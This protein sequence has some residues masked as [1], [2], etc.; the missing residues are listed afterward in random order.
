MKILVSVDIEGV[1]GVVG[2]EETRAGSPEHDRA[3][4]LMTAEASAAVA[5]ALAGGATEV[6]VAD[7]HGDF[8]NLL[9]DALHPAARAV[10]GKPRALGM[11]A[12]IDTGCA[13][14]FLV[15]YHAKARTRGNLA[16]TINSFAF[17]RV[18][19]NGDE[20]GEAALYGGLAGECGVPVALVT[21]DDVFVA[22]T[23]AWLPDAAVVVV[24]DALG[25]R[26]AASLAPS[27]ACEAIAAGAREAMRRIPAL[28]PLRFPAPL[29]VGVDATGPAL[30]DLFALLPLVRR[31]DA[32]AVEFDAGSMTD[33]VRVLNALSAM[34]AALR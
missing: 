7:A 22:E 30:A 15:G 4:R 23:R 9:P 26:S 31:V 29:T 13:A 33:A 20:I 6:L 14:A 16:H 18:L 32:T 12:G 10:R 19:V 5:G 28:A 2:P 27:A 8:R 3:R 25:H 21:G 34:S 17:A 24:K 1:A 11:M